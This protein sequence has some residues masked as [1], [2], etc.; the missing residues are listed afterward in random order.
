M[1]DHLDPGPATTNLKPRLLISVRLQDVPSAVLLRSSQLFQHLLPG[2]DLVVLILFLQKEAHPLL[3]EVG[4]LLEQGG[5]PAVHI[6]YT[7]SFK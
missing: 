3:L 6:L 2:G 4:E 5:V 1:Y 7:S